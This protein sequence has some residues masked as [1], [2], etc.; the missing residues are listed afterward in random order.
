[1]FQRIEYHLKDISNQMNMLVTTNVAKHLAPFVAM[2]NSPSVQHATLPPTPTNTRLLNQESNWIPPP[3]A[4]N[5]PST[6]VINNRPACQPSETTLSFVDSTPPSSEPKRL[7]STSSGDTSV[8]SSEKD[9]GMSTVEIK[10]TMF[11]Y[12]KEFLSSSELTPIYV[13][14]RNR[15]NFAALL[16]VRLFD[17]PTR[18]RSNVAGRGKEKLDPEIMKFVK[19]KTFE[20]YECSASEV[21]EEW[22]KCIVSIDE[23]SRALKKRK[24]IKE[25]EN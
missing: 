6:P 1:M 21:K 22:N 5:L 16:V 23:K 18:M 10:T 25:K 9:E 7:D 20:Y 3:C 12:S 2:T 4:D 15:R 14:S 17:I 13:K 19:A 11:P 8:S 24:C